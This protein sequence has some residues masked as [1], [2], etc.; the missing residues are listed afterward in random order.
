MRVLPV[1]DAPR[2]TP[3]GTVTVTEDSGA[4]A[5]SWATGVGP[6]PQEG[7]QALHFVLDELSDPALFA[8]APSL[9][10][11]GVLRFTPAPQASGTATVR[12]RLVDDGGTADGGHDTSD[13]V[14]LRINVSAVDDAPTMEVLPTLRA[15]GDRAWLRVRVVDLDST[16]LTVHGNAWQ[17]GSPSRRRAPARFARSDCAGSSTTPMDAWSSGSPTARARSA[18]RCGS[19]SVVDRRTPSRAPA[20][21]PGRVCSSD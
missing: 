17:T 20:G 3:G 19:G 1:D 11:D 9:G 6:G 12:A 7:G 10:P 2:F 14:M 15:R 16:G 13:P 8:V 21:T 18:R 4:Y 5:A